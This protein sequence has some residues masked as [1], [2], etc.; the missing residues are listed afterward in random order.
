[1]TSLGTLE[2]DDFVPVSYVQV[3]QG[4]P[5]F[6]DELDELA[7]RPDRRALG[8][9]WNTGV[10]ADGLCRELKRT[11]RVKHV[12]EGAWEN[13]GLVA[14]GLPAQVLLAPWHSKPIPGTA[15]G[16]LRHAVRDHDAHCRT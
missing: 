2:D 6:L 12:R 1:M 3:R 5:M 4:N 9:A 13:E 11:Q 16:L 7:P 14:G 10:F 8:S 15:A